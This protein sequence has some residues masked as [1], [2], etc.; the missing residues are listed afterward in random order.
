M[1]ALFQILRQIVCVAPNH[2]VSGLFQQRTRWH[3]F[4]NCRPHNQYRF[5]FSPGHG[6]GKQTQRKPGQADAKTRYLVIFVAGCRK[7]RKTCDKDTGTHTHKTA[8]KRLLF[9]P[10]LPKSVL[11]DNLLES[12]VR[13]SRPLNIQRQKRTKTMQEKKSN[14]SNYHNKKKL[15]FLMA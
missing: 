1:V 8:W 10:H 3:F 6:H 14:F 7:G 13:A 11:E 2:N 5:L 9:K 12:I 15:K 4:P